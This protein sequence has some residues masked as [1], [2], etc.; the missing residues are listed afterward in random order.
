MFYKTV[1]IVILLIL[2]AFFSSAETA[3]TSLSVVQ[4]ETLAQKKGR[5]GRLV[6]KLLKKPEYLLT[7]IL[8][9]NNL[10]NISLTAITTELTI[11]LFGSTF[12]GIMTGC[13]TLV[14]LIFGEVIP[15]NLA[16]AHNEFISSLS[17]PLIKLFMVVLRPFVYLISS[18]SSVFT[19]FIGVK[20]R[21]RISMD[22]IL[23]L[24]RYAEAKGVVED[25]E[26]DMVHGVFRLAQQNITSI[27]T[28]RTEV[29]S[30]DANST[31]SETESLILDS[32]FSRIP[33][34][35]N[36]I[37]NITGIIYVKD[38]FK[39]S[40]KMPDGKDIRL[41]DISIPPI[42]VLVSKKVGEILF[43]MKKEKRKMA[44]VL[45]EY[46]GLSGLVTM[47]DILEEVVGELYDENEERLTEK[48]VKRHDNEYFILGNT[49]ISMVNDKIGTDIPIGRLS[50]TLG[51]YIVNELGRIPAGNE[52]VE[53]PGGELIVYSVSSR[54][55]N[56]V[57]LR[58]DS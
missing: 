13:L 30:L 38:F 40:S 54:K 16:I 10:V 14:V 29:F 12:I 50:Q 39:V 17:A 35:E 3:F 55:V 15:K 4:I 47:E 48:I 24:I 53:I 43:L 22:S 6:K 46:S 11:E 31:I 27:M 34:Y 7:T 56:S 25:Y 57:I 41:K 51:G 8:T 58:L 52:R 44:V 37:E 20:K 19:R 32:G 42:F 49:P 33:I 9:G 23:L 18:I 26:N 21:D 36:E 1:E 5:R 28:H 45:D 2:S